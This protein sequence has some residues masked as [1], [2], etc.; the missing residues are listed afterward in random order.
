MQSSIED[1]RIGSVLNN[2]YR[3]TE[4]IASGGMGVVYRGERLELGRP[5]A[6]K[7]LHELYKEKQRFLTRFERE[8]RAMSKLSHPYCVS[9]IDFGVESA[10]Y[11]VMDYVTGTTLKALIARERLTIGRA[12]R[13]AGQVLAA[14]AH[15]H[16][17]GIIHRDIKPDNIIL[18]D[19]VG[20]G[21]HVRILDFGLAK[22]LDN[23]VDSNLSTA[24]LLIGTPNYMSPEQSSG[25]EVDLRTD[26]YSTGVVLFEMLTGRKPFIDEEALN[27][28]RM[29]RETA[30]PTLADAASGAAAQSEPLFSP[31]LEEL[32]SKAMA[33]SPDDRFQTAEEFALALNETPEVLSDEARER[34]YSA[35]IPSQTPTRTSSPETSA[36]K[37]VPRTTMRRRRKFARRVFILTAVLAVATLIFALVKGSGSFYTV[38]SNEQAKESRDEVGKEEQNDR[39]ERVEQSNPPEA[40]RE[41][42]TAKVESEIPTPVPTPEEQ[43]SASTEAD[44]EPRDAPPEVLDFTSGAAEPSKTP[45]TVKEVRELIDQGR[46]EEAIEGLKRLRRR[47]P[48]NPYFIYLLGNLFFEKVWWGDAMELYREA[49]RLSPGYR[50]RATIN[51]NLITALGSDKTVRQA[52]AIITKDVG[53]T[54]LPFLRRAA[55]RDEK[56]LVR[57]RA[58]MLIKKLTQ[59]KK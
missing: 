33:K 20:V 42:E 5:V 34:S 19:A 2:R 4:R 26:L 28:L 8:A 40:E 54:A 39:V 13:I 43:N 35:E 11:I 50:K 16:E 9:V 14:L 12:T 7:F 53:R 49:I 17:Q 55:K 23:S 41:G 25:G 24:S 38:A 57:K 59:K 3:I 44:S 10:P 56:P 30:P 48:N 18:C 46:R 45:I 36:T 29:H 22:L 27:V 47:N 58:E 52:R 21:E 6:I 31:E 37:T 32:M 15:A 1:P 51:R